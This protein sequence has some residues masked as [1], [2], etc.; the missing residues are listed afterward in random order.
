M[1]VRGID[2]HIWHLW[3]AGNGWSTWET[4]G[5]DVASSPGA[6]SWG[7]DRIDVFTTDS[8]G[9]LQHLWWDGTAWLGWQKL[10]G[11]LTS[12]P[13]AASSGDQHLDIYAL[14]LGAM[15]YHRTLNGLNWG[16]WEQADNQFWTTYPA[17]V[18][19]R[20]VPIDP[21]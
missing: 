9:A 16:A 11:I 14:G 3:W 4:D 21:L 10:D 6:V 17:S 7:P 19:R 18:V 20:P 13:E 2:D 8:H 12:S 1:V 15:L 5:G